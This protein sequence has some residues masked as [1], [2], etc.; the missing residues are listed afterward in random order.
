M[1]HPENRGAEPGAKVQLVLR[2]ALVAA[3]LLLAHPVVAAELLGIVTEVHDGDSLTLVSG[4]TAYRIRLN[5]IDAPEL[6]QERGEDSR[7]RLTDLCRTKQATAEVKGKDRYGRTLAVLTCAGVNANA[8]QVRLGWAWVY[9]RYAPKDSPLYGF[10]Q[11]AR[12][13]RRGLWADAEAIPP[14]E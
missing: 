2:A 13:A 1:A 14:W 3:G 4:K 7:A 10:Q 6:R 8:E 5:D 11:E 12:R 9:V